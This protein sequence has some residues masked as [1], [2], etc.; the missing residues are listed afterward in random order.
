VQDVEA[1]PDNFNILYAGEYSRGVLRSTDSG[2]HW[3]LSSSGI[4]KGGRVELAVSP[5]NSAKI[6]ACV[7][8]D[9]SGTEV[10]VSNDKPYPGVSSEVLPPLL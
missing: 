10:Y 8:T 7:E 4:G 9:P 2:D 1:Q 3:I 6:F 5:V